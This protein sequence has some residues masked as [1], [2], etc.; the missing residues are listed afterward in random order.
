MTNELTQ[1]QVTSNVATRIE[2]MK[3]EGLLIA[4]NYSVSNALSSAY[5]ALKTPTVG[6]YSS[7]ALKT[8]FITRY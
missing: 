6:I 2:A 7:N 8:A 3:G 4:P 5:Y 1:K